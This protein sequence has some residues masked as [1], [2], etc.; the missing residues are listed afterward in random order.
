MLKDM[1]ITASLLIMAFC[2]GRLLQASHLTSEHQRQIDQIKQLADLGC[3]YFGGMLNFYQNKPV[4][5]DEVERI[6]ANESFAVLY[7]CLTEAGGQFNAEEILMLLE[8]SN[9]YALKGK[10]ME[11]ILNLFFGYI[12]ASTVP[13]SS[14][15]LYAHIHLEVR[16]Y[17]A[18]H[19]EYG[20][21]MTEREIILE[22]LEVA[23]EHRQLSFHILENFVPLCTALSIKNLSIDEDDLASIQLVLKSNLTC[24]QF[25]GSSLLFT[26]NS[27]TLLNLKGLVNL[28]HF[29]FSNSYCSNFI[30]MLKTIP[31]EHLIHL[32]ISNNPF[33]YKEIVYLTFYLKEFKKLEFLDASYNFYSDPERPKFIGEIL[34]LKNL[35][36]LNLRGNLNLDSFN[37]QLAFLEDKLNLENLNLSNNRISCLNGNLFAKKLAN[38]SA[39]RTLNLSDMTIS[40][41]PTL[42]TNISELKLLS[43]LSIDYL[44]TFDLKDLET[45]IRQENLQLQVNTKFDRLWLISVS[46]ISFLQQV[47]LGKVA[48]FSFDMNSLPQT[49]ETTDLLVTFTQLQTDKCKN[50][51][52]I[53][54]SKFKKLK[55]LNVRMEEFVSWEILGLLLGNNEAIEKMEIH[56]G[57]NF[58]QFET[59]IGAIKGCNFKSFIIQFGSKENPKLQA[60]IDELVRVSFWRHLESLD[61]KN[62]SLKATIRL[63]TGAEFTNLHSISLCIS[64]ACEVTLGSKILPTV[65]ALSLKFEPSN[66]ASLSDCR[67]FELIKLFPRAVVLN[68]C[69]DGLFHSKLNVSSLVNLRRLQI[70]CHQF[71]DDNNLV[72]QLSSLSF[73]NHLIV[74]ASNEN[75]KVQFRYGK[76]AKFKNLVFSL[77]TVKNRKFKNKFILKSP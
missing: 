6:T 49:F 14:L 15:T 59:L 63:L 36:F 32:D 55:R 73:L 39:L 1:K 9:Y 56:F 23:Q 3:E 22:G 41:L 51:L 17:L 35:K 5:W 34:E 25:E 37:E 74:R 24:L 70:E 44:A 27:T 72:E 29:Q 40:Q 54:L 48:F 16:A 58:D 64:G 76:H 52:E 46:Q 31:T 66:N 28:T 13:L 77:L 4:N 21:Q 69:C 53:V 50:Y 30:R 19:S 68:I 7:R 45:K 38:F 12:A 61:C 18:R 42:V 65:R 8:K 57:D 26:Y 67:I 47:N 20:V 2:A 33:S 60:F 71:Q 62:L 43:E 10:M 11:K 75:V